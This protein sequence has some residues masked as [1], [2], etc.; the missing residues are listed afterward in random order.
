MILDYFKSKRTIVSG[1]NTTKID[2]IMNY[3]FFSFDSYIGEINNV[4]RGS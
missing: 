2:W 1:N 4:R 3:T